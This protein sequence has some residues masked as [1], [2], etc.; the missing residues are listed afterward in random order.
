MTNLY[1]MCSV[2]VRGSGYIFQCPYCEGETTITLG[3]GMR[4]APHLMFFGLDGETP[5]LKSLVDPH[6]YQK[7]QN[8]ISLGGKPD[9]EDP[10]SYGHKLYYCP[11]CRTMH[12]HFFF[13]IILPDGSV[14]C[15]GHRCNVCRTRLVLTPNQDDDEENPRIPPLTDEKGDILRIRCRH[16]NKVYFAPENACTTTILWD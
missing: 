4:Y 8:L 5:L 6:V 10:G 15:P 12:T 16:C 1:R 13:S 9:T 2:S 11:R 14:W 7:A 3:V